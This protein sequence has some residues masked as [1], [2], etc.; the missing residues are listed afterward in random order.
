MK[1]TNDI[2]KLR[3]LLSFINR[4]SKDCTVSKIART[5]GEETYTIS[6]I[7]MTLEKEELVDRSNSRNP[8]LTKKGKEEARR[9]AER[10]RISMNHLLYEGV[11]I[12]S[13]QM[14]AYHWALYNSE[15]SMDVLRSTDEIYRVKRELSDWKQFTGAELC[16]RMQDGLY[17]FPFLMYQEHIQNGSNISWTNDAFEHPCTLM[18]KDG[19]GILRLYPKSVL[20]KNPTTGETEIRRVSR[21]KYWEFGEEIDAENIGTVISIPASNIRFMNMG[22]GVEQVLHGS[23]CL[24]LGENSKDDTTE[25]ITVIFTVLI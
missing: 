8:Q 17:Q 13:A 24:K 11:D 1:I 21:L 15:K 20:I 3:T 7:L 4:D 22:V 18:I 25:L 6:R 19:K 10:I 16:R 12:N 14:D 23:L 2:L 5:L 9:Y